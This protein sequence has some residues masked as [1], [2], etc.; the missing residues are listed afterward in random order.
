MIQFVKI[1]G[2]SAPPLD[3]QVRYVGVTTRSLDKRLVEHLR[4]ARTGKM[5][6]KAKW[7]RKMLA[8]GVTPVALL[9]A[10]VPESEWEQTEREHIAAFSN[11]TNS[12]AGGRGTLNP[13]PETRALRSAASKGKRHTPETRAR[14]SVS[15]RGVKRSA[16]ARVRMSEGQR[17]RA[18]PSEETRA[19]HSL[20]NVGKTHSAEARARMSASAKSRPPISDETR[21]RLGDASR[22]QWAARK[23]VP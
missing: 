1:Y 5:T 6:H 19:R 3:A 17:R 14:M 7:L 11:L 13:S 20:A 10:E 12:C 23:V 8:S 22:V 9:L 18:P 2:L 15:M 4:E 21:R 16:E